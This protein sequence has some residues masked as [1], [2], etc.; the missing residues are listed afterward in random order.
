MNL[1]MKILKRFVI[2][3]ILVAGPLSA[4][5]PKSPAKDGAFAVEEL[6]TQPVLLAGKPP[7]YP[8]EMRKSGISGYVVVEFIIT[9][10]GDVVKMQV[11]ESSH[12]EFEMPALVA[13]KDW[14]FEPGR[15]GKGAVTV[16]A[17]ERLEFAAPQKKP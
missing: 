17:V 10:R 14:K 7:Q 15:K 6:D 12:R 9:S 13:V 16:R 3:L 4:D 1:P 5:T 11:L 2:A 8:R